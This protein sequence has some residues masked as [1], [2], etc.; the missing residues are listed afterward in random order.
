MGNC[1]WTGNR[2]INYG[3]ALNS[4][5]TFVRIHNFPVEPTADTISFFTVFMCHHIKP[6]SVDTYLSGICQQLEPYF[7]SVREIPKSV[8]C[9]HTLMGC[10]QLRGVPTKRKRALTLLDLQTVIDYY[11]NSSSSHNDLLFVSQLLT[12]FFALMRLGE[13]TVSDDKSFLDYRKIMSRTSLSLSNDDYRFFLPS[14]KADKFFEGNIVIIQRHTG[15][16]NPLS[17]FKKYL[18]SRDRPFSP[19]LWL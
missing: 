19:D 4:Y 10:K 6:D 1:A 11:A 3:S 2:S 7:P 17:F 18:S 16:I 5:L 12:S 14:H 8:L 13:L 15:S 9:K